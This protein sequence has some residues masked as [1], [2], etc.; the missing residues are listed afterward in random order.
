MKKTF[1]KFVLSCF[2]AIFVATVFSSCGGDDDNSLAIATLP[3]TGLETPQ[4]EGVSAK[5]TIENQKSKI[6]SLELTASGNYLIITNGASYSKRVGTL[7]VNKNIFVNLGVVTRANYNNIIY[8]KFTKVSDTEYYLEDYGIVKITETANDSYK[9]EVQQNN[10]TS[11]EVGA[12]K[13]EQYSTSTAT[14]KLC[15]TWEIDKLGL[16]VKIKSTSFS[17][18]KTV[19]EDDYKGLLLS[20]VSW[21]EKLSGKKLSEFEKEQI[22]YI[23]D[24]YNQSRPTE[25]TFTKSGTYTVNYINNAIGVAAWTWLNESAGKVQ[26]SWNIDNIYDE[27]ISGEMTIKYSGNTMKVYETSTDESNTVETT[28]IYHMNEVK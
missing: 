3:T 16:T 4:Y 15:R 27:N 24:A 23:A 17:F 6:K 25:I 8:G 18:S 26:Y 14:N 28:M 19:E 10:G 13:E 9:I 1:L 12:R 20:Y 21:M 2:M 22:I 5:Y 11:F 7:G